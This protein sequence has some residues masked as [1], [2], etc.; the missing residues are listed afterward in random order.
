MVENR[1]LKRWR[2]PFSFFGLVSA[3][4]PVGAHLAGGE[5]LDAPEQLRDILD[6]H[7]E[8]ERVPPEQHGFGLLQQPAAPAALA[9]RHLLVT[10]RGRCLVSG[11]V[12][13][14]GGGQKH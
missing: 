10:H 3:A 13:D 5:R 14:M 9:H 4:A 6:G 1:S 8:A 7:L 11:D 12:G 2:R